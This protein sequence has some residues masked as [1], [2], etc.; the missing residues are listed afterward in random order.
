MLTNT[1]YIK[2]QSG[3]TIIEVAIVVP[4]LALVVISFV[5]ILTTLI[6]SMAVTSARNTLV[7]DTKSVF[8]QIQKDVMF[9]DSFAPDVLPSN[10][11]NT[12]PLAQTTTYKTAGTGTGWMPIYRTLIINSADQ[13][14]NPAS[15]ASTLP[16]IIGSGATCN[17]LTDITTTNKLPLAI[18]YY[19]NA[20]TL[21]RRLIPDNTGIAT[22]GTPLI[23]QNCSGA[24]CT[25][26]DTALISGVTRFNVE[27]FASPTDSSPYNA[28]ASS[29]SPTIDSVNDIAITLSVSKTV[30][31]EPIDYS[32]KTRVTRTQ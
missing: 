13:I 9:S 16:A 10:F 17:N 14:R 6:A 20:G 27:Y 15:N 30:A 25:P 19:V 18:I 11:N 12:T 22:C 4:M 32:F 29:P 5:A 3:F 31:S 21:Y 24:T 8:T 1:P 7:Y 26:K 28:Y 2:R 23:R